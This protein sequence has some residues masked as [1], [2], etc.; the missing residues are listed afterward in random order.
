[1][2]HAIP[3][4]LQRVRVLV[5]VKVEISPYA[6]F[7]CIMQGG[8]WQSLDHTKTAMEQLRHNKADSACCGQLQSLFPCMARLNFVDLPILDFKSVSELTK[9]EYHMKSSHELL[10]S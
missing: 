10:A 8:R 3:L 1:M 6:S 5:Q 2:A 7:D 4:R 9:L